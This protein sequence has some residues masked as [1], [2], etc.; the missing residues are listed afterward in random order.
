M[1]L[2]LERRNYD[3]KQ[4]VVRLKML[5]IYPVLIRPKCR[6]IIYMNDSILEV[7]SASYIRIT[8]YQGMGFHYERILL[9]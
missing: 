4:A 5:L 9:A 2:P 1:F 6:Y 8:S 3:V 7:L